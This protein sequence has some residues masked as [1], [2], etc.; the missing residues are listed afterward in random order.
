MPD[1]APDPSPRKNQGD[2]Q[3]PLLFNAGMMLVL[4]LQITP[5]SR[6]GGTELTYFFSLVALV[7]ANI[8]AAVVAAIVGKPKVAKG[9]LFAILGIFLI[10][11]GTC[12]YL[13]QAN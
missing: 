11:L 2:I 13:M 5:D 9:F 8:V 7:V 12:A 3:W 6:R 4:Y 1:F 10:G